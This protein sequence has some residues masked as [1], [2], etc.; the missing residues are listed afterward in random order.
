VAVHWTTTLFPA[1]K[2]AEL[3][4]LL[5]GRLVATLVLSEFAAAMFRLSPMSDA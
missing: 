1:S 3:S 2:S 4:V 5:D